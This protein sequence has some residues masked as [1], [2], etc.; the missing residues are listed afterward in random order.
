MSSI[1][2]QLK[3]TLIKLGAET[4]SGDT[5]AVVLKTGL[6]SITGNTLAGNTIAEVL[7]SFNNNHVATVVFSTTPTG[8]TIVV[9][10]GANVVQPY[11]D[12]NYYLEPGS[13]TYTATKVGYVTKA[14]QALTVLEADV[15]TTKTVNVALVEDTAEVVFTL[16]PVDATVVVKEGE[17]V[18]N[19]TSGTTYDL[20]VGNYTYTVSKAGYISETDVPLAV[21]LEDIGTTVP[22]SVTLV[23]EG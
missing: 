6:G 20:E 15:N 23:I 17:T 2:E 3:Q 11:E 19:P 16:D 8:V 13:Y 9:K 18:I 22:V 1:K 5:I 12:G 14:D 7:N 4:V 21:V 10:S